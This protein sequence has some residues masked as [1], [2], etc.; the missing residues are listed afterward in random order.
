MTT[1]GDEQNFV[2]CFSS[3]GYKRQ[4]CNFV[5]AATANSLGCNHDEIAV[6]RSSVRQARIQHRRDINNEIRGLF[7]HDPMLTIH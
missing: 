6:S 2:I 7:I 5:K 4:N 1:D 3:Y